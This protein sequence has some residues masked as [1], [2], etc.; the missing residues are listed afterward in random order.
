MKAGGDDSAVQSKETPQ[1][2][3][4]QVVTINIVWNTVVYMQRSVSVLR[5][6]C[7]LPS[8][9]VMILVC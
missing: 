2:C 9:R 8:E 6:S 4:D 1:V 3:G 7:V 5:Q